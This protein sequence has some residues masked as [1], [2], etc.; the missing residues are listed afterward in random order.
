MG[1]KISPHTTFPAGVTRPSSLTFTWKSRKYNTMWRGT[2]Y[3][4]L[5]VINVWQNIRMSSYLDNG[6]FSHD[7][8]W[9]VHRTIRV[10][11]H[12]DH[13]EI[14]SAFEF[15]VCDVGLV[16]SQTRRTDKPLVL[17]WFSCKSRS[18]KCDFCDHPLPLLSCKMKNIED[19]KAPFV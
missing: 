7:T 11:L 18:H 8:K 15:R 16:K 3:I 9:G 1:R 19:I 4:A 6:S 13:L 10:F 14:E 17:W 5:P 2:I 12:T